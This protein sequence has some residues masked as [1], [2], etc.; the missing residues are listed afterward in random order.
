M[1]ELNVVQDPD[2]FW[3]LISQKKS[4]ETKKNEPWDIYVLRKSVLLVGVVVIGVVI[5]VVAEVVAGVVA[6][7]VA[8]VVAEIMEIMPIML[9]K[10]TGEEER[11]KVHGRANV[12]NK[13]N[14]V[15]TLSVEKQLWYKSYR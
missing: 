6:A 1:R 5:G 8:G 3:S 12:G 2:H 14:D 4:T 9:I 7:A 13:K 11:R 10:E 15:E